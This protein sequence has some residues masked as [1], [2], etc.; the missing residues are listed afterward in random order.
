MDKENTTTPQIT[1][2]FRGK[3]YFLPGNLFVHQA[4]KR[5]GLDAESYLVVRDGEVI[6]E[7]QLLKPG[8]RVRIVPVISGGSEL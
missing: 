6:T 7:D 8:D 1:L 4:L 2:V 3:E 5:I